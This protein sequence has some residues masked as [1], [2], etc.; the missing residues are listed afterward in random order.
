TDVSSGNPIT[1]S[2]VE[3]RAYQHS[4]SDWQEVAFAYPGPFDPPGT[5]VFSGLWNGTFRLGALTPSPYP[6]PT[7][8]DSQTRTP[9]Y[10]SGFYAPEYNDNVHDIGSAA[11]ITVTGGIT[12]AGVN[13]DLGPGGYITGTV[14]NVDGAPLSNLKVNAYRHNGSEWELASAISPYPGPGWVEESPG[15]YILSGLWSDTYRLGFEPAMGYQSEYYDDVAAIAGAAD[16]AVT[17]GT[18]VTNKNAI[19]D[20]TGA[21]ITGTVTNSGG[22]PLPDIYVTTEQYQS[23]YEGWQF[24][25]SISTNDAGIYRLSGLV[26]GTYRVKFDDPTGTYLSQYYNNTITPPLAISITIASASAADTVTD[27]DAEMT[28]SGYISGVVTT[29][30]GS[31]LA[32][33]QVT[34]YYSNTQYSS[35]RYR[36]HHYATTGISGTYTLNDLVTGTYRLKFYDPSNAYVDEY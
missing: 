15:T 29:G 35:W 14:H 34:A 20:S 30:G 3:V 1:D 2:T 22:A 17:V 25:T 36:H 33:I 18:T 24:A 27:I 28:T 19:L 4:G 26:T 9:E 21:A 13:F 11:D 31:P 5:Y 7:E 23:E 8:I 16:I 10:Y 32:G 6:G 12:V